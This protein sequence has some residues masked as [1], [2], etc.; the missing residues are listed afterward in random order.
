MDSAIVMFTRDLR[1]HDNPALHLACGRARQVIPLFVAGPRIA[2]PPNRQR[3][4]AQSLADLREGLRAL[5]GDLVI[6]R[7]NP[8][9]EVIRLAGQAGATAVFVADDVSR[10]AVR[11]RRALQRECAMAARRAIRPGTCSE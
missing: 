4:L 7:G 10:Y 11:R 1:L 5:G 8:A 9:A 2:A 3:F 6:R